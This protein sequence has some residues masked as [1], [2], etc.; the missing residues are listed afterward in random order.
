MGIGAAGLG[1][2]L[3]GDAGDERYLRVALYLRVVLAVSVT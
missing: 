3:E 2:L 1:R